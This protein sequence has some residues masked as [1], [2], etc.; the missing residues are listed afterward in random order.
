MYIFVIK[1]TVLC[2][3]KYCFNLIP[4]S[5]DSEY[6]IFETW[7]N[8]LATA[9]WDGKYRGPVLGKARQESHHRI[10]STRGGSY[11]D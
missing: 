10:S 6:P 5:P 7:P 8:I 1:N 9:K 4:Y 3:R 11:E 2:V